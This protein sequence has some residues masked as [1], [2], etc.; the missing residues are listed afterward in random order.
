MVCALV[1]A[2]SSCKNE[3]DDVFDQTAT[4]RIDAALASYNDVLKSAPNGWIMY[5]Y[6][7]QQYGG[8]N[9][10]MKF[11]GDATATIAN[12]RISE[13][14]AFPTETSHYKLEQ[15]SGVIL[16][17]DEY[18]S[19][20]HYYSDPVNPEGIG[21]NG[22]GFGGD[23][24]FR[25]LS[26][27]TERIEMLGKKT[28][29]KI[30]MTPMPQNMGWDEYL[31]KIKEIETDMT[32]AN[33]YI[34]LDGDSIPT[35]TNFPYRRFTFTV[36][37]NGVTTT[38]TAPYVVTLDGFDFY[39]PVEMKGKTLKHFN[40]VPQAMNYPEAADNTVELRCV[41]PPLNQQFIGSAWYV[42]QEDLSSPYIGNWLKMKEDC[43]K[44]EGENIMYGF[45][46]KM[47]TNDFGCCIRSGN[48]ICRA[49]IS[50]T[51]VDEDVIAD[52]RVTA[53]DNNMKYYWT[54]CSMSGA[55]QT[56]ASISQSETP[57]R[58]KLTTDFIKAPSWVRLTDMDDP[59]NVITLYS[60]VLNYPFGME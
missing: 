56:F 26:A 11:N 9:V 16:S 3:V 30:I 22:V 59:N 38:E 33:V 2:F 23:L 4:Q 50:Y 58:F 10:L 5:F 40:Y 41:V 17:F 19:V 37:D 45:L 27:T 39:K 52:L 15:S 28:L 18:N 13:N 34:S 8:Y 31:N 7:S 48:Y 6:G 29:N 43:W 12:E 21:T 51:L 36:N 46:G 49:T 32:A 54:S 55:V 1:V 14:G 60:Q 57:K 44:N 25:I 53:Q 24:E 42:K 47:S 35:A 20:F